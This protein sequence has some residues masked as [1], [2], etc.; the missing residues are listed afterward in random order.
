MFDVNV[1]KARWS[2]TLA[3]LGRSDNQQSCGKNYPAWTRTRRDDIA[4]PFIENEQPRL[5]TVDTIVFEHYDDRDPNAAR[6]V[7]RFYY[8]Y[9]WG[10]LSWERWE[11]L[12]PRPPIYLRDAPMYRSES[13]QV[14]AARIGV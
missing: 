11:R 13:I 8:G 7:E 10:W 1:P 6:L 5:V 3:M 9:N 2:G 12:V 4:F 14:P